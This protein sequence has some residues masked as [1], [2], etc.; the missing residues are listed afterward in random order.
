MVLSGPVLMYINVYIHTVGPL[1][2]EHPGMYQIL[3][4]CVHI[5]E[6]VQIS[7]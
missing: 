2:S 7:E 1:I 6:F 3:L 5:S 4:K